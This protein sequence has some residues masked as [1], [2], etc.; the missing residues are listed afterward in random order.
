MLRH[1]IYCIYRRASQVLNLNTHHSAKEKGKFSFFYKILDH[2]EEFIVVE[3]IV[4]S[5]F[6]ASADCAVKSSR[7]AYFGVLFIADFDYLCETISAATTNAVL[8]MIYCIVLCKFS[9]CPLCTEFEIFPLY[10]RMRTMNKV[11]SGHRFKSVWIQYLVW[12][13]VCGRVYFF[14]FIYRSE[15]GYDLGRIPQKNV[16]SNIFVLFAIFPVKPWKKFIFRDNSL[17]P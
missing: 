1:F 11:C 17:I 3:R 10:F 16:K 14:S 7:V 12:I 5:W 4:I 2:H 13:Y 15:D 8:Q 9:L 6:Y